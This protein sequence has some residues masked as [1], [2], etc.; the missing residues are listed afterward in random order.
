M[1]AQL[2]QLPAIRR[3]RP[4]VATAFAGR[5]HRN[6]GHL[7]A[8]GGRRGQRAQHAHQR[9]LA[10]TV[11]AHQCHGFTA[12]D[13]E[14]QVIDNRPFGRRI[15]IGQMRDANNGVRHITD[16]VGEQRQFGAVFAL[17][18][19]GAVVRRT[20]GGGFCADTTLSLAL[21]DSLRQRGS[22]IGG[23]S[24]TNDSPGLHVHDAIGMN[25]LIRM[26]RDMHNSGAARLQIIQNAH[27]FGACGFVQ[28]GSRFVQYQHRRVH[29]QH[30]GDG[31]ALLLSAAHTG[32]VGL[33]QV[34]QP[35]G[36]Q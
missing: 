6:A 10:R 23:C 31:G 2:R 29:G 34:R 36:L 5:G 14:R 19:A 1:P 3:L 35:H 18:L 13:G 12:R 24:D 22:I 8:A 7:D 27:N 30:A 28:H 9:R 16:A 4:C 25:G 33:T 26:M 21:R 20:T 11:H 15:A 17:P 32:R